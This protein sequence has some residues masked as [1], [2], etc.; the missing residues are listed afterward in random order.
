MH[1]MNR[2]TRGKE[3]NNNYLEIISSQHVRHASEFYSIRLAATEDSL[4]EESKRNVTVRT[5]VE[6]M[7]RG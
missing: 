6:M 2:G 4:S 1:V 5:V 7:P 3:L